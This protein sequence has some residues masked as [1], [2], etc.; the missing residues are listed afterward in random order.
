MPKIDHAQ[1]FNMLTL[2]SLHPLSFWGQL[3]LCQFQPV[4][5][6]LTGGLLLRHKEPKH[7]DDIP[8]HQ[9]NIKDAPLKTHMDAQNDGPLEKVVLF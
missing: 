4:E 8:Q 6:L 3:S 2:L 7:M 9:G 5:K 1:F